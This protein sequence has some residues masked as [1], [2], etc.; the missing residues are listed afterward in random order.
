MISKVTL[1]APDNW[2]KI[3][4]SIDAYDLTIGEMVYISITMLDMCISTLEESEKYILK[5]MLTNHF[6][7]SD[8][9]T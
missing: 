2:Q 7:D 1:K 5:E 6:K 8:N 9:E 3:Q 4:E